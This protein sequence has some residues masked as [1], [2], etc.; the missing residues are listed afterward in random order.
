MER[1]RRHTVFRKLNICSR[2]LLNEERVLGKGAGAG[3]SQWT[4][5]CPLGALCRVGLQNGRTCRSSQYC[6]SRT[7]VDSRPV[8]NILIGPLLKEVLRLFTASAGWDGP[9]RRARLLLTRP[10]AGAHMEHRRGYEQ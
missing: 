4:G 7:L 10:F 8:S 3:H 9:Q 6:G 2:L 1:Y 5:T